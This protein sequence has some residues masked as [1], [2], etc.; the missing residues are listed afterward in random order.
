M[1]QEQE[2]ELNPPNFSA[3]LAKRLAEAADGYRDGKYYCF[4][5]KNAF[6]YDIH[7]ASGNTGEQAISKANDELAKLDSTQYHI[8]GPYQT[9]QEEEYNPTLVYDT[10]EIKFLNQNSVVQT[11][12]LNGDADCVVFTL[13]AYDKF[14]HPYFTRLY[15]SGTANNLRTSAKAQ[16]SSSV[17][18]VHR[19]ST[20]L[21]V[22]LPQ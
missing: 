12:T 7:V 4:V 16:L 13:S 8:Y 1:T 6:P 21:G 22:N 5:C 19:Y 14:F 10:I 11:Q 20:L 18:V 9:L 17:P 3:D 15:G 2:Q